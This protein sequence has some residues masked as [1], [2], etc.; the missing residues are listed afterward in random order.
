MKKLK[1]EKK[2][3]IIVCASVALVAAAL[4][5]VSAAQLPR[6]ERIARGVRVDGESIAG[7]TVDEARE[8]ISSHNF[9]D[10]MSFTLT[11]GEISSEI[12]GEDI[13]LCTDVD[14]T[15][16]R[17]YSVGRG[18]GIF[19]NIIASVRSALGGYDIASCA[20]ADEE[21]LDAIIYE[22][23][24]EKNGEIREAQLGEVTDEYAVVLPPTSGQPHDVSRERAQ[25]L[26]S[27][28]ESPVEIAPEASVPEKL[29]AQELYAVIYRPSENAEYL[30]EDGRL[31]IKDETVGIE[32]DKED[33]AAKLAE[34]N[35]GSEITVKAQRTVPEVTAAQLGEGLFANEL[36]S[37][38]STYST[39]AVGRAYNVARAA[40]SINGKILLPGDTFSYNDT[41]GNPSLANGYR[42]APIYENGKTS[43]GVGGGVCQVSST[44]YSAVLYANLQIVERRSHSLTVAYVPKGQDATVAYGAVDFKFKNDT[45][46]PIRIDASASGGKCVVKIVGT[47]P[48]TQRE[49]KITHTVAAST[50]PTVTEI[51]DSS[52]EEGTRKVKTAGKTGYVIDSV[53]TVYENGAAVKTEKLSRSTYKMLP[54]E[55]SVGTMPAATPAAVAIEEIP[56][57]EETAEE[58]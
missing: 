33:I 19:A 21:A 46:H 49:V 28:P 54:T 44:L 22:M 30:L 29:S 7:M 52:M 57:E 18:K 1:I 40:S 31:Y 24:V 9:Y 51:P 15:A 48:D 23:G 5:A 27:L 6:G 11:C 17:A 32:P 12:N 35:A 25:V 55:V 53:R 43:E 38:K 58:E 45:A 26:E 3:L 34:F 20:G 16:E 14:K 4:F 47:A 39:A 10:G 36:A 8:V 41:I 2:K 37:Y 42:V 56:P 50:E 13:A